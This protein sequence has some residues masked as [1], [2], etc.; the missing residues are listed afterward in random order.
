LVEETKWR[1]ASDDEPQ[2]QGVT[3]VVAAKYYL[4]TIVMHRG[5]GFIVT[6]A[7]PGAH[8]PTLQKV[9]AIHNICDLMAGANPYNIPIEIQSGATNIKSYSFTLPNGD[10]MV[11]LW[12]D[13]VAVDE[14]PGISSTLTLPGF[15]GWNATGIDVLNSFEQ[16][17]I[18]SN[19]NGN[20]VIRDLLIKDYPII[21]RL[22]K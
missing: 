8:D 18:T 13:G 16:K 17:L 15:A 10:R 14:D 7:L 3:E 4:R 11:A 1:T 19:E 21:I 2:M 20:L 5:L 22:A 12:T 6:I 9:Q